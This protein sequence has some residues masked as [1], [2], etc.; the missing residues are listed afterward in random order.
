MRLRSTGSTLR[1]QN[2]LDTF[3]P[4]MNRYQIIAMSLELVM[5]VVVLGGEVGM[6]LQI[7]TPLRGKRM[8]ETGGSLCACTF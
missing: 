2:V 5:K 1:I 8:V 6:R 4:K 3:T 7:A